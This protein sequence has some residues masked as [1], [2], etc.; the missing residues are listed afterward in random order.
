MVQIQCGNGRNAT[1]YATLQYG[2]TIM[3]QIQYAQ[4]VQAVECTFG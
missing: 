1:E 2:Q 3:L 4:I